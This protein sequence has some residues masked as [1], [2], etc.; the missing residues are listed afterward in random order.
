[1]KKS[2]FSLL[3]LLSLCSPSYAQSD[4]LAAA[5]QNPLASMISLP[6]QNNTTFGNRGGDVSNSLNIQPVLPFTLSEDWNLITRTILPVVSAPDPVGSGNINGLGDTSFTGWFS[7]QEPVNY[8]TWGVGPTLYMPT[9]TNNLGLDQWG[10]GISAV[11]VYIKDKWVAGGLASNTWGFDD[12]DQLN[13]FY[14]QIFVNYNMDNGWYLVSAPII[15]ANWNAD[16]SDR[17]VVPIG[18]GIGKIMRWG[19]QPVNLNAQIYYNIEK[20][21]DYGDYTF[22]LQLQFMFPKS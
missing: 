22:R 18:G 7:P 13:S 8:I 15:T 19:K 10:G 9:A 5:A 4:D 2:I 16:S 21:E 17:W 20:P 6:F 1:M 12:T 14:S 3:S 11:G